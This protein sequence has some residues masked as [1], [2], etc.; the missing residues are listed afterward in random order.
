MVESHDVIKHTLGL[1][2]WTVGVKRYSLDVA[3]DGFMPFS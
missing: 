1:D 3:V 2:S